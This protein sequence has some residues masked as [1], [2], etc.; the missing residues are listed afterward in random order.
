LSGKSYP[1]RCSVILLKS[2][3]Y[4]YI[5]YIKYILIL[6]VIEKR[7]INLSSA[8]YQRFGL[9]FNPFKPM[10]AEERFRKN[11]KLLVI[12]GN[13][14]NE[15]INFM[16]NIAL[17]AVRRSIFTGVFL[18]GAR[19]SG[20]SGIV[21]KSVS[22]LIEENYDIGILS[23]ILRVSLPSLRDFFEEIL[24][25]ILE[26]MPETVE[27]RDFKAKI[28]GILKKLRRMEIREGI[29]QTI[30]CIKEYTKII[31]KPT[32]LLID[33]MESIIGIVDNADE[34]RSFIEFL[35]NLSYIP[36]ET[37]LGFVSIMTCVPEAFR[38]LMSALKELGIEKEAMSFVREFYSKEVPST[39]SLN[40][41]YELF[42]N[43]LDISRLKTLPS[44]VEEKI[45]EHRFY[46]FTEDAIRYIHG[47]AG[48]R[49]GIIYKIAAEL[50]DHYSGIEGIN[51]IDRDE[52]VFIKKHVN[53]SWYDYAEKITERSL[54][55]LIYELIKYAQR[56]GIIMNYIRLR[57]TLRKSQGILSDIF[58]INEDVLKSLPDHE[59]ETLLDSR[60]FDVL[61]FYQMDDEYK[62]TLL[63]TIKKFLFRRTIEGLKMLLRQ[64][65][66]VYRDYR[67]EQ[68]I[69][70]PNVRIVILHEHKIPET[71]YEQLQYLQVS[72]GLS[73]D[74]SVTRNFSYGDPFTY[75]RLLWLLDNIRNIE[76][77]YGSIEYTD[78][79]VRSLWREEVKS[80]LEYLGLIG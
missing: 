60:P 25:G 66:L 53:K 76:K 69:L 19:G 51:I 72:V 10:L 57:R 24:K 73:R 3:H 70:L 78:S 39:I 16:K 13:K 40:D 14:H 61:I 20:K 4:C 52:V 63:K 27:S 45:K 29:R 23:I 74:N 36:G 77:L 33:Q 28:E 8:N 32:V 31:G 17:E 41:T 50:L 54:S 9:E 58:R 80:F 44:E 67:G 2:R 26:N 48:G 43:L 65:N 49:P 7:G 35:R 11:P 55:E 18:A 30:E 64:G 79:E 75:G 68:P 37:D 38:K 46:P 5:L 62:A 21:L 34:L 22:E 56:L 6:S 47:F 1:L 15:L 42:T 59:K 12:V 71:L